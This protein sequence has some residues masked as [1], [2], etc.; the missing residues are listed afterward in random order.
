MRLAGLWGGG[1]GEESE[2]DEGGTHSTDLQ[3]ARFL[4]KLLPRTW[5]DARLATAKR[6]MLDQ[7]MMMMDS[8]SGGKNRK[9]WDAGR[10]NEKK[11]C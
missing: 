10:R 4:P 11:C 7:N 2:L 9:S 6:R 8:F 3:C 5:A 1:R